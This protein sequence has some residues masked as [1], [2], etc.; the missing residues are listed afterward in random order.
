MKR[1]Y[2]KTLVTLMGILL[3]ILP[4]HAKA[5]IWLNGNSTSGNI[6]ISASVL[7]P[8]PLTNLTITESAPPNDLFGIIQLTIIGHDDVNKCNTLQISIGSEDPIE[9][10]VSYGSFGLHYL[11]LPGWPSLGID[12]SELY[13]YLSVAYAHVSSTI[14]CNIDHSISIERDQIIELL[15]LLL[16]GINFDEYIAEEEQFD[17][18]I[19]LNGELSGKATF[20]DPTISGNFDYSLTLPEDIF[21]IEIPIEIPNEFEGSISIA[22]DFEWKLFSPFTTVNVSI[23]LTIDGEEKSLGPISFDFLPGGTFILWLDREE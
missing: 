19:S 9:L 23:T 17:V 7:I 2:N 10:P 6:T 20:T 15:A 22:A 16:P 11:L 3:L 14:N 12:Q 21:D 13:A 18:D 5:F 4:A 8:L 1:R